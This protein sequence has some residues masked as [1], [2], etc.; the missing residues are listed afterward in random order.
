MPGALNAC[1]LCIW[2]DP[3]SNCKFALRLRFL[4]NT[5]CPPGHAFYTKLSC[6]LKSEALKAGKP[7]LPN[8]ERPYG[9]L[10]RFSY[11]MCSAPAFWLNYHITCALL[12]HYGSIIV[13]NVLHSRSLAP[14]SYRM[15]STLAR[16]LDYCSKD[17]PLSHL[18]AH[19]HVTHYC[20]GAVLA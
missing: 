17:A 14:L 12:S 15:C 10:A 8:L 3:F 6:A 9:V 18:H 5:A 13:Y 7:N 19:V 16:W 20:L 11:R 2:L 4:A 1:T